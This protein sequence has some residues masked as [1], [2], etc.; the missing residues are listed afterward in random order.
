MEIITGIERRRR[1]RLEEKLRIMA[2]TEEPGASV[3]AVVRR[4]EVSQGLL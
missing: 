3:V 4:H 1:W 2:K